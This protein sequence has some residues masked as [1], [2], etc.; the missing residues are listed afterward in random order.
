MRAHMATGS[1]TTQPRTPFGWRLVGAAR[2][3]PRIYEEVEADTGAIG[4]AVAVVLLA[5]VAAGIGLAGFGAL[6]VPA[7]VVGGLAALAWW[8]SWAVLTYLIGTHAFPEPQT[9]ADAGELLR[10]IGF[11]AA[12][13]MLWAAGALP[14]LTRPVFVLVSLWMLAA[15][16]VAVRQALDYTSTTRAIAVCVTGWALSLVLAIAL[17]ARVQ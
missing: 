10:T 8:A 15:M 3:D 12:P 7:L 14:G 6:D 11:S 17:S 13:G 5:T 1:E 4:Q 9:R 16:V 2:L